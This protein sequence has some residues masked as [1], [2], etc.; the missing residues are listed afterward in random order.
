MTQS[1]S[2]TCGQSVILSSWNSHSSSCAEFLNHYQSQIKSSIVK[3]AKPTTNRST[4]TCSVCSLANLDRESLIKHVKT[5]HKN[6]EAVCPICVCQPWGDSN[7]ITHL[8]GHLIKRHK[9]D[10]DTTVDYN[11]TE[12]DVLQRVLRESMMD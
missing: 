10:Y 5:L 1:I 12:D 9:F 3:E 8:Y 6:E 7:Y 2:C 4:F 11:E